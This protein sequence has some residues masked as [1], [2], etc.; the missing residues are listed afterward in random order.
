MNSRA[1]SNPAKR[2]ATSI[3]QAKLGL[4]EVSEAIGLPFAWVRDLT[5]F[6]DEMEDTVSIS[7]VRKIC[8][9]LSIDL[10]WLL[11]GEPRT[12]HSSNAP[13]LVSA[14]EE[15]LIR[16][17][18]PLADFEEQVNYSLKDDAG[19]W[20]PLDDWNVDWL[21]SVTTRLGIDWRTVI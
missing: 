8:R 4:N 5:I 9:L 7:H 17:G 19:N 3:E 10:V 13:D 11:T 21:K 2:F 6:P 18:M 14:I 12:H 16:T 20:T 15:Y 1:L